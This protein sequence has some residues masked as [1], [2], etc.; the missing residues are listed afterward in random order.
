MTIETIIAFNLALLAAIASPGPA[1]LVAL[2]TTLSA[3]RRAGIAIGCGLGLMAAAWT[4]MAL[5]GLEAVFLVVPWAYAT[6][7]IAGALYLLYVAWKMWCG[8]RDPLPPGEIGGRPA[9]RAFRHGLVIN[10]LNPKSVLFAAAVLIVIFPSNMT[11][12]EN[13]AVVLNHLAIEVLF[14]TAMAFCMSTPV[15]RRAYVRAKTIIDRAAALVLGALGLRL[16][17]GK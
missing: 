11:F 9:G 7:K 4:M 16:L 17:L 1:F 13:A 2:Q 12:V 15:V 6:V 3:G 10:V 14:Y 5:L 8:A